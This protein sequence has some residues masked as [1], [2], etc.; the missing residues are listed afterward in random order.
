[1]AVALA[2]EVEARAG[3]PDGQDARQVDEG[4]RRPTGLRRS[5]KRGRG[6]DMTRTGDGLA[7][8]MERRPA[9]ICS[10]RPEAGT[11]PLENL[12]PDARTHSAPT[13]RDAPERPDSTLLFY[14]IEAGKRIV[15][16]PRAGIGPRAGGLPNSN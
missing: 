5:R 12:N 6:L 2:A 16:T 9:R 3:H 4:G 10:C 11:A 1:M 7:R 15:R 14:A 8:Q 13:G